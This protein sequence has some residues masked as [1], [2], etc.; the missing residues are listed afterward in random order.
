MTAAGAGR[1]SFSR[2]SSQSPARVR[3]VTLYQR[4]T[5][6]LT[7]PSPAGASGQLRAISGMAVDWAGKVALPFSPSSTSSP[8]Q[9]SCSPA[10]A[11]RTAATN[12]SQ[13]APPVAGYSQTTSTSPSRTG[14]AS[15]PA[16]GRP[17]WNTSAA[18]P[19]STADDAS[20][21]HG[22]VSHLMPRSSAHSPGFFPGDR[23]GRISSPIV[24]HPPLTKDKGP[25]H[26]DPR[27]LR[28]HRRPDGP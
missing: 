4:N 26:D 23:P 3:P 6:R 21:T 16:P 10:A 13:A 7:A 15:T 8:G 19:T 1:D 20:Q 18:A 12:R 24:G 28:G 22:R 9:P 5:T 2:A 27:D 14:P 11:R 25:T 17:S